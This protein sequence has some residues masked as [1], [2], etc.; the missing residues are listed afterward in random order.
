MR[1]LTGPLVKGLIFTLV[2]L[3][4]TTILAITIANRGSGDTAAYKARFT[5]VTSLNPGDD[6]RMSG[7]RVGQVDH[8]EIVDNSV[9][10]VE[11]SVD[12]RWRLTL[13]A[14]A[15]IKFRNLIGQRYI[16]LDQGTGDATVTMAE[17]QLIPL[18][19]TRP[20]LDL[21]AMFN[22]F[23]PLFQ[24]LT[25]QDVNQLS[26]E[27]VQVLQGEGGTVQSL[28]QHTASLTNTLADKDE[29]IGKVI[30]NLNGVL[31]QI[32]GRGDKLGTLITTTQQ[33]VTGLAADAKP[34]GDALDSLS[35]LATSSSGLLQAGRE[36]LRR[37]IEALGAL[38]KTLA[39][40]SPAFDKFI[41]MLPT[42]YETIGRTVSY[43]SWM[44]LYLCGVTTNVKPGP[45][46]PGTPPLPVGVPVTDARCGR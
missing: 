36:P 34:I 10:E 33:L 23:K 2:T 11:F 4:A 45:Q 25:P 46:L 18:E 44:N 6:V 3:L 32:N 12:R 22:G 42:K 29:V 20:A 26:F 39:D 15:A 14:T 8:I 21:T 1:S 28:I 43:G 5:D 37:D 19:R 9:A 13:D 38:S 27:I 35:A 41:A 24:A 16:S 40:N 31:E 30:S 17:G 7:V